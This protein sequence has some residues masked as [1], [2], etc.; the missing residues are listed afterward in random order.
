MAQVHHGDIQSQD[1]KRQVL[2]L[3][4]SSL[5]LSLLERIIFNRKKGTFLRHPVKSIAKYNL[6]SRRAS[7]P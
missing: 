5:S 7:D 4:L 6:C 2:S 1:T 3:S